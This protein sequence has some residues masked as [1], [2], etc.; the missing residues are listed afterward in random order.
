MDAS[1]QGFIP[2]SYPLVDI[3]AETLKMNLDKLNAESKVMKKKVTTTRSSDLFLNPTILVRPL[4]IDSETIEER[5]NKPARKAVSLNTRL[6][7]DFADK[8]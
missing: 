3:T 1:V 4:Y 7:V 5:A 2:P 6:I 8:E